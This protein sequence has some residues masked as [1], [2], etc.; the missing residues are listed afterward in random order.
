MV[1]SSCISKTTTRS[2]SVFYTFRVVAGYSI[3]QA[4]CH[5]HRHLDRRLYLPKA[6]SSGIHSVWIRTFSIPKPIQALH[7]V[8]SSPP[9]PSSANTWPFPWH[10]G[11]VNPR[12]SI[13]S[14]ATVPSPLGIT[15]SGHSSTAIVFTSIDST[16][17]VIVIAAPSASQQMG[18]TVYKRQ[19]LGSNLLHTPSLSRFEK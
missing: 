19:K 11:Q 15:N 7:W 18:R 12:L 8:F 14:R 17:L 5:H 10:C 9:R 16:V 13:S 4:G 3:C 2:V 6:L 1:P